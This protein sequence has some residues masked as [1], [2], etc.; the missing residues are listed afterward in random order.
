MQIIRISVT[1]FAQNCRII[2]CSE[3]KQAV[4]VDLGG[5]SHK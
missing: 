3:T 4:V 1:P 5:Y 2:V